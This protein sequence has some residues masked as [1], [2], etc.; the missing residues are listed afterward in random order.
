M[1]KTRQS[2]R[3][4]GIHSDINTASFK[5][6]SA[7]RYGSSLGKTEDHCR[8]NINHCRICKSLRIK[9]NRKKAEAEK[10][11]AEQAAI[12]D[13]QAKGGEDWE[14]YLN[15]KCCGKTGNT[16]RQFPKL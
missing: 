13:L 4:L 8:C 2:K 12:A 15:S 1:E 14:N 10:Q 5:S 6:R 9:I 3:K 11:S 16:E 7:S